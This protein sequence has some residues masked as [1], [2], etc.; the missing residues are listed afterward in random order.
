MD[1]STG[2]G[3]SG[4]ETRA[5]ARHRDSTWTEIVK[6]EPIAFLAIAGSAGFL[7]GGG[8]RRS[9][10]LQILLRLGQIVV[11]KL[12]DDPASIGEPGEKK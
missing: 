2:E 3:N 12:L 9:G 8:A 11:P 6:D 4:F 5:L 10:S 1:D 7:V